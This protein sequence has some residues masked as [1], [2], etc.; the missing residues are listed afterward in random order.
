MIVMDA[1]YRGE[2]SQG[3]K[4][5]VMKFYP[6]TYYVNNSAKY[7]KKSVVIL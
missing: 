1:L 2:L 7:I 6:G 5:F 3:T 4:V